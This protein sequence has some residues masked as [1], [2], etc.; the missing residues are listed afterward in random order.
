MGLAYHN[1]YRSGCSID[2]G[3]AVDAFV[4]GSNFFEKCAWTT[5]VLGA[6]WSQTGQT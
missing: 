6:E 1:K 4:Y 5:E 3:D 2:D